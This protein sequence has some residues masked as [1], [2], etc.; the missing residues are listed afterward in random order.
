MNKNEVFT[1]IQRNHFTTIV[2]SI[3]CFFAFLFGI[4]TIII[5]VA[6][7]LPGYRMNNLPLI[8][9]AVGPF[10][11]NLIVCLL[12]RRVH[13]IQAKEEAY[14]EP[15]E[16]TLPYGGDRYI[17]HL[18]NKLS[19]EELPDGYYYSLV[20]GARDILVLLFHM[21]FFDEE[22]Y[23][24]I[25]KKDTNAARRN[26]GWKTER[27]IAETKDSIRVNILMVDDITDELTE[28]IRTNAVYGTKYAEAVID[29]YVDLT[30]KMLY[31]PAYE[32]LW[33][34]GSAKYTYCV[35]QLLD[36]VCVK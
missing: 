2:Y 4:F 21:G 29:M 24:V 34:G 35:N 19:M 13:I 5:V 36:I 14:V 20:P 22:Q 16:I 25:R 11:I 31:I 12:L 6:I 18:T 15:Y 32:S 33:H 28:E 1:T 8:L 7:A 23:K 9:F 27:S 30:N 17:K 10:L 26:I 3:L